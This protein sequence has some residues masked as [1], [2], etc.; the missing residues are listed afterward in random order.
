MQRLAIGLVLM[1]GLADAAGGH[2]LAF[3][4][5][6]LA[7][8]A[9]AAAALSALG[10]AFEPGDSRAVGRAW[11]QAAALLLV[12]VSAAARAPGRGDG[13]PRFAISALVVCL[14]LYAAQGAL[15]AW[16]GVRRRLAAHPLARE[17]TRF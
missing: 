17:L 11:V 14:V 1:A 12:L 3:Y 10:A 2:R 6:V 8:P 4:L 7:V 13:V 9:I 5:L 16:P 15:T